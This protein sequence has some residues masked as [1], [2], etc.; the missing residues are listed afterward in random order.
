VATTTTD[1]A[2]D[3]QEQDPRTF[4]D[5]ENGDPDDLAEELDAAI[6]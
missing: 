2:N 5:V 1:Q 4:A 3:A 6:L